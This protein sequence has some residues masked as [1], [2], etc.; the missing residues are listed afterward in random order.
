MSNKLFDRFMICHI[1]ALDSRRINKK[2]TPFLADSFNGYPSVTIET[3]PEVDLDP[4]IMTGVY[5]HTH[6]MWQ[7][8]LKDASGPGFG[9]TLTDG[10]PE[11]L[12]STFQCLVHLFTGSFDLAGVPSWRRRRFEIS[13]TRFMKRS[14]RG[15]LRLNGIDTYLNVVGEK[16]CSFIYNERVD[17]LFSVLTSLSPLKH[18]LQLV[19][20]HSLDT[21]QHWNLDNPNYIQTS[22][23]EIDRFVK[24]LHNQCRKNGITLMVLSDHGQEPVKRS[25]NILKLLRKMGIPKHEYTY[26]IEAPK[27]R[28]W[29]HSDRARETILEKLSSIQNS[30]LLSYRDLHKY[31]VRFEEESFGEYYLIAEPG[32]I[33]F[34]NDFYHPLA[35]I[36]LGVT[37]RQQRSRLSSPQY[38]GYHGYLPHN[39]SEKGFMILLDDCYKAS[40]KA[41]K[42]IDVAPTV[43][44]LL[45]YEKPDY[46]IGN[47][48]FYI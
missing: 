48:V 44:R 8:R 27:A 18:K 25:I 7:V 40:K 29:F 14:V 41:V 6:K 38:R 11:V 20:I 47:C 28:F 26:Y 35:N 2:H 23:G 16:D 9:P 12:T 46:M 4:T 32:Y 21:L 42:I 10:V 30:T 34:P 5:P 36:F 33:Y 19:Q 24:E 1:S 17:E 39:E 45:G 13:K 22:Y 15:F 37:D 43:L 31:N 3:I